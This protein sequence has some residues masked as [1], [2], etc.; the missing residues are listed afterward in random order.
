MRLIACVLALV[1]SV[2]TAHAACE[3][4]QRARIPLTLRNGA[5]LIDV[6]INDRSA[7]M[8]LDTGAQRSVVS[9][10]AVAR[11]DLALDEWVATTMRGIGGV[12][13]H[14][15]ALPRA[16]SLGGVGLERR[17]RTRDRS[18]TV[19]SLP[20]LGIDG[21]LGRDYLSAFDLD[22][23][24]RAAAVTLYTV[25]G[26]STWFLPWSTPYVA[27]PVTNPTEAALVVGVTL[28]GVRL[29]A[30]LDTGAGLT[31][32]AAPGMAR[33]GL[34]PEA[35]AAS[36]QAVAAGLGPRGVIG[37]RHAFQ[38]FAVGRDVVADPVLLVAPVRLTPIVD[39]LLGAD[40]LAARRIWISYATRQIFAEHRSAP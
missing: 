38:S 29:R 36:P 3:V 13:R 39:M 15:N 12:E 5:I 32:L 18:L 1:L 8:I 16:L 10:D 22:L 14:R 20:G 19:G 21:L 24:L 25:T 9:R 17:T 7:R 4:R 31:V 34:T 27:L 37:R 30:L 35:L 28:D 6:M 11:L 33:M 2:P 23:D 26:C 40:W